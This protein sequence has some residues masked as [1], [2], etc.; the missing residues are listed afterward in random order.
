MYYRD[1]DV[2]Q[3]IVEHLRMCCALCYVRLCSVYLISLLAY[4]EV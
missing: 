1:D 4:S 3:Y 2:W